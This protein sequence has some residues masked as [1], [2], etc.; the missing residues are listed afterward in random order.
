MV[1]SYE[2]NPPHLYFQSC[3]HDKPM[4]SDNSLSDGSSG[5]SNGLG[6][7]TL[8][9]Q[10]YQY[11]L[12]MP[13][14]LSASQKEEWVSWLKHFKNCASLN[15][16]TDQEKWDFLT[17]RL[18]GPAKE[19]YQSLSETVQSGTFRRSGRGTGQE[20]HTCQTGW[21]VQL[22]KA[23]FQTQKKKKTAGPETCSEY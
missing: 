5:A 6:A 9:T 1:Q 8:A 11:V 7:S 2:Y 10:S 22:Y 12:V 14:A 23:E 13:E 19:M 18:R 4:I 17:V 20:I 21:I 15:K 3:Y 16:W